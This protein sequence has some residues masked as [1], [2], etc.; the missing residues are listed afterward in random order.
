[1][2]TNDF[3]PFATASGA[4]VLPQNDYL[5]MAARETG[6][7]NG[8]IPAAAFNKPIRQSAFVTSMIGD[9]IIKNTEQD[10]LDDGNS[11]NA[12]FLYETGVRS[13]LSFTSDVTLSIPGNYDT[14]QEGLQDIATRFIPSNVNVVFSLAAGDHVVDSSI[15]S[16][17]INHPSSER[18][19]IVG[20]PLAAAFPAYSDVTSATTSVV[21]ALLRTIWPTRIVVSGN[22]QGIYLQAKLGRLENILMIGDRTSGQH[23]LLIGEWQGEMASGTARVVNCWFHNFG[24]D[25]LRCNYASFIQGQNIGASHCVECGFRAANVSGMQVGGSWIASRC[26]SGGLVVRDQS[27]AEAIAGC[28]AAFIYSAHGVIAGPTGAFVALSASALRITNNTGYGAL[29]TSG[30][31]GDYPT[32][33]VGGSNG[34]GDT[35]AQAGSQQF[36]NS[37]S[38]LTA[39]PTRGSTG[40]ANSYSGT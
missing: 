1:M 35:I 12:L 11:A 40:N 3:L 25:G 17:I 23:G 4:T 15:G 36:F 31:Y 29:I 2:P 21:E 38:G 32:G 24:T 39:S 9:F 28:S 6:Y 18:I 27:F 19:R 30:S 34:S 8:I 20:Q 16:I 10:F 5:N 26:N 14:L 7:Q 37:G 22:R 13:L 33:A